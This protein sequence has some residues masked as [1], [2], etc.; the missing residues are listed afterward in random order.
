MNM[1]GGLG[2]DG[3]YSK[4]GS[5]FWRKRDFCCQQRNY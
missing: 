2:P 5:F 1:P 4:E 3:L